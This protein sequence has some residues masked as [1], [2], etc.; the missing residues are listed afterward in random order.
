MSI[1]SKKQRDKV[2]IFKVVAK[3][4]YNVS[5]TDLCNLFRRS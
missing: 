2:V 3:E 4:N 5:P 1:Y